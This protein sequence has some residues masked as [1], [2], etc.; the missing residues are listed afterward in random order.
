MTSKKFSNES[1]PTWDLTDLYNSI[2]DKEITNDFKIIKKKCDDFV[3]T[4]QNKI[5]KISAKDLLQAIKNY[6]EISQKIGKIS[7]YSYLVY[8]SDLSNQDNINFHQNTSEKINDLENKI[9]FF[10]LELNEL[11][12]KKF[13][14]LFADKS[15]KFYQP[16]LRDLR[17][18]KPYQLS[19]ELEKFALEKDITSRSAFVRLFDETINNLKFSYENKSLNSQE[20]FDLL[21]NSDRKIRQNAGQSIIETFG[22]NAKLFAFITNILAKDKAIIDQYRGFK[23]PISPRNLTNFV[24]DKIV[25]TLIENVKN[26]YVNISHKYYQLKAKILNLPKLDFYDRGAPLFSKDNEKISWDDAKNLVLDAYQE[27]NPQMAQIAKKFFDHN[28]IDAKVVAGKD[29]GAYSHPCVP[30]VHPYILMNF[31]GKTRDVMT[32]AHELGHGIHQYLARK[33]GYLMAQT[34]LTLAETA[35]VFGEQLVFQKI[36]NNENNPQKKRIIIANKIEDMINTVVRQIAFLDF[37]SKI[38]NARKKYELP[39]DEINNYWLE[40]QKESLGSAFNF[41]D[42]YKYFWCYIPHFIHSPFYVYSY[43]F[44]DC[45]V[46]SL[47]GIYQQNKIKDFDNKYLQMLELGGTKHHKAMLEPFGLDISKGDFWQSGLNVIIGYINQLDA[48]LKD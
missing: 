36:L 35:S 19:K 3:E 44:G 24:E 25:E 33:Q 8:S 11:S 23:N 45:L 12:N 39:L 10:C 26:N 18:F 6:E 4:Y 29:S 32:L 31:Q 43:A 17:V 47:Y 16:F 30:D 14:E 46:N 21:S 1:L 41:D 37:E 40:V 42:G 48:L 27:F 15:L 38:H 13:N 5:D 20:I 34:P 22:N 7:T 9:L 28:W 2:S